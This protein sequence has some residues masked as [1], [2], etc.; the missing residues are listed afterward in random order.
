MKKYIS[1]S[2]FMCYLGGKPKGRLIEQH[3][4][5]FSIGD[6][7][8]DLIPEIR[9]AWPEAEQASKFHIDSYRQVTTEKDYIIYVEPRKGDDFKSEHEFH[10]FF[11]NLGGYTEG[12]FGEKHYSDLCIARNKSEAIELAK[13]TSFFK[14]TGY[15]GAPAHVDDKWGIDV[16]DLYE[17]HDLLSKE[18]KKDYRICILPAPGKML[19]DEIHSGFQLLTKMEKVT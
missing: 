9:T 19:K 5:F 14:H 12:E 8:H 1:P 2:L 7:I 13:K 4:F 17:I 15:E 3:D 16:D 10:L 11:I 18:L 6:S